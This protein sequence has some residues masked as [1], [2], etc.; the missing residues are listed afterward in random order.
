MQLLSKAARTSSEYIHTIT[1]YYW[2]HSAGGNTSIPRTVRIVLYAPSLK[3][4]T[5]ES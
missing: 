2:N 4:A 5:G 3:Y 1:S